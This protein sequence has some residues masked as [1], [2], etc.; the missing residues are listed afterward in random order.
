MKIVKRMGKSLLSVTMAASLCLG[1]FAAA[2]ASAAPASE[3]KLILGEMIYLT[4][5]NGADAL[6]DNSGMSGLE[7]SVHLCGT[8]TKDMAILSGTTQFA[9]PRAEELGQFYIWNYNDPNDLGSCIKELNIQVSVDGATWTDFGTVTLG[10]S[11]ADEDSRL[12][13]CVACNY[14][15]PINFGGIPAKFI[16]LTP[17]SNYG[18]AQ[19]GLSEIRVFRHK[20][21]PSEGGMIY[22]EVINNTAGT[23]P[24]AAA[25]NQGMS[26]LLSA[27]ATHNN[28]PADMWHCDEVSQAYL[29]INLDG[30]YPVSSVTIWNYNDPSNLGAGVK[31]FELYYT[32]ESPCSISTESGRDGQAINAKINFAGGDWKKVVIDKKN[33]FT[34]P[35]GTG[36]ADMPASLTLTFDAPIEAQHMKLVAKNNYGG[37]GYGISEIRFFAGKGWGVEP[38]RKWTGLVSS[39]GSFDYQGDAYNKDDKGYIY[40]DGVYSYHMTGAQSQGSLTDDSVIFITFED[41]MV[42][43][44]GNYKNWT[45]EGGYRSASHGGWV[46][47]SYLVLKGKEPDVRNAQFYLQ[48]K[49]SDIHPNGNIMSKVYWTGD[50]TWINDEE[51]GGLY[52]HAPD[53]SDQNT[54]TPVDMVKVYFNEDKTPNMDIVPRVLNNDAAGETMPGYADGTVYENTKEAGAPHPDGY[55]YIYT[56]NGLGTYRVCRVLPENYANFDE[57]EFWSGEEKGWV[58][59]E[60]EQTPGRKSAV[61][62]YSPGAEAAI[63]YMD[64]GYFAGLYV[65]QYT[66]GSIGGQMKL[67][68]STGLTDMFKGPFNEEGE[69][70]ASPMSIYWAPEKYK[71]VLYRGYT[72]FNQWDYNSKGHPALSEKGELLISYHVGLQNGPDNTFSCFGCEYTH[73]VFINLFSIDSFKKDGGNFLTKPLF[74]LGDFAVPTWLVGVVGLVVVGGGTTLGV[75]LGKKGKKKSAKAEEAPVEAPAEE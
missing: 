1:L 15:D 25:N 50:M 19:N 54:G 33:V 31:D 40:S 55:I 6:V 66:E 45:P 5:V 36:D 39:S 29:P 73:P 49:D 10:Q 27:N 23:A 4:A 57:Y 24:E 74:N 59:S 7:S 51:G 58:G 75:L 48:G 20:T 38:A 71:Y 69:Q 12:G 41:T 14:D 47:M 28:N 44:M 70:E 52:L 42:G 2:P 64:E 32:V 61:S 35:Q 18:G 53:V 26:D 9:L 11:S 60:R 62:S 30:T 8:D 56:K 21:R 63:A 46:N 3:D 43:N 17:V 72:A 67:G 22:G 65:N 68:V 16:A 34:L 37:T 13:G